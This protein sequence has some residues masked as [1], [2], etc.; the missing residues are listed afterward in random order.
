MS[1]EAENL[2]RF[3]RWMLEVVSH[4]E[5]IEAGISSDDAHS[6]WPTGSVEEI[7]KPGPELSATD[8]LRIYS[9]MYYWRLIDSLAEDFPIVQFT[10]GQ[11][12]F[13]EVAKQ[14]LHQCPSSSPN[15]GQL[16]ARFP[17]FLKE[18]KDPIEHQEFLA[19]LAAVERATNECFD[20]KNTPSLPAEDILNV[21]PDAWG[22]LRLDL[23]EAHRRLAVD[24]PVD[25][26]IE[27]RKED[28]HMEVPSAQRSWLLIYRRD[29]SVWRTVISESQAVILDSL[30]DGKTLL[31]AI[32]AAADLPEVD[33]ESLVANVGKWFQVWTGIGLFSAIRQN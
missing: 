27:A 20:E 30:A 5:G 14:Y 16:G 31:D 17:A 10:L 22:D 15:L 4:P 32:E 2:D 18:S 25:A 3:E 23:I 19:D 9:D 12:R 24:F 6:I 29:F 8:R 33:F 28:R 7:A 13:F 11:D 21:A 26:F 1:H